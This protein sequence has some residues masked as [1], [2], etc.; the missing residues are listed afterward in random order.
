MDPSGERPADLSWLSVAIGFGFI[1]FS[2]LLSAV[3]GLA[4]DIPASLIVAALRCIGQLSLL[5]LILKPVF[6]GGPWAVAGIALLLNV[7]GTFE[8][9]TLRLPL[10]G[11]LDNPSLR[12]GKPSRNE[13][14]TVLEARSIQSRPIVGTPGPVGS[15]VPQIGAARICK[16]WEDGPQSEDYVAL[17]LSLEVG[18]PV[19]G[20]LCGNTISSIVVASSFVLREI[21]ENRDKVETYLV[22]GATRFEACKPIATEAI[23]VA[24]LPTINQMA[25]IGLISIPGTMT[26]TILGGSSLEQAAKLQMIMMF[27]ITSCATLSAIAAVIITLMI[28]VDPECRL[29]LDKVDNEKALIWKAR[30]QLARGIVGWV[31]ASF[32]NVVRR[33]GASDLD[34]N[35]E[36]EPLLG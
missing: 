34:K 2:V 16:T 5:T 36:R 19:L 24:L 23:R 17:R 9:D 3:V 32:G 10:H 33:R 35:G 27:L 15:A 11:G 25:V 31:R 6:G 20:M 18:V 28:V 1:V 30:D 8:A 7:T 13:S 4:K 26:G 21:Q 22:F 29:R 14:R 12:L